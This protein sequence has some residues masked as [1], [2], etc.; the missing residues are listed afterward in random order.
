MKQLT[1]NAGKDVGILGWSGRW[2]RP[3]IPTLRRQRQVDLSEFEAILVYRIRPGARATQR[4]PVLIPNPK[5][6]E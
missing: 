5:C 2:R 3:L 1:I 6:G 4:N